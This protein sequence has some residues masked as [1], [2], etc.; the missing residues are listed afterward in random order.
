MKGTKKAKPVWMQWD[1]KMINAWE[2]FLP[3]K[4]T[5]SQFL[6]SL[7]VGSVHIAKLT[8]SERQKIQEVF[9]SFGVNSRAPKAGVH[10]HLNARAFFFQ[11]FPKANKLLWDDKKDAALKALRRYSLKT[12]DKHGRSKDSVEMVCSSPVSKPSRGVKINSGTN[13]IKGTKIAKGDWGYS[14]SFK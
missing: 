2:E 1:E 10:F 11:F 14:R 7:N 5:I 9:A 4:T 8:A 3:M 6:L 13:D 12:D